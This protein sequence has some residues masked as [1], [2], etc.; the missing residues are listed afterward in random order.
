[1]KQK[2]KALCAVGALLFAGNVSATSDVFSP[3]EN[4]HFTL[5]MVPFNDIKNA[6]GVASFPPGKPRLENESK[7]LASEKEVQVFEWDFKNENCT[8]KNPD[9]SF[10]KVLGNRVASV[11]G[12]SYLYSVGCSLQDAINAFYSKGASAFYCVLPNGTIIQLG[13]P[14]TDVAYS[15][16]KSHW[17]GNT[18]LNKNF[19]GIMLIT[20]SIA[21][22]NDSEEVRKIFGEPTQFQGNDWKWYGYPEAQ[23]EAAG[24]LGNALQYKYGI[25]SRNVTASYE[26]TS[27]RLP[28]P[29]PRFSFK[30]MFDE[31]N[32][33]FFPKSQQIDISQFSDLEFED[34]ITLLNIIGYNR[35]AN[36]QK[37]DKATDQ[38]LIQAFKWRAQVGDLSGNLDDNTKMAIINWIKSYFDFVADRNTPDDVAYRSDLQK[39]FNDNAR[40]A[41]LKKFVVEE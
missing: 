1:M 19:I 41:A 16:G 7:Y 11:E 12:I 31:F 13:N 17:N 3:N 33:G 8:A 20:P 39:F 21:G 23:T 22:D 26:V 29:G 14:D 18:S 40:A 6:R 32:V 4:K 37:N 35:G 9:G 2:F 34:Y 5:K 36:G 15:F 10:Q 30:K 28:G 27:G 25:S 38:D 24:K